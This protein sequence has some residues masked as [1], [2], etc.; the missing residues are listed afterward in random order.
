MVRM[1]KYTIRDIFIKYGNEYIKKH[2]LS[3]NEWKVY[4]SIIN[5]K[6]KELGYHICICKDC[7]EQYLGLKSCR[8]RHCPMC[9]SYAREKWINNESSY[10]LDSKYFHI[11]T[12]VPYELNEIFLYNKKFV[13]T[14]YLKR[15][16]K[17]Y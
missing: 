4:N 3:K 12:T 15:P 1:S 9:Q 10:L 5:C 7:G 11:V 13:I 6:T 2:S 8:N 14:F 16:L 17:Q